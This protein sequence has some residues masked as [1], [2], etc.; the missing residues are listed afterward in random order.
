MA[1]FILHNVPFLAHCDTYRIHVRVLAFPLV[2]LKHSNS[3]SQLQ[4]CCSAASIYLHKCNISKPF[5]ALKQLQKMI[6]NR[7]FKKTHYKRS[8]VNKGMYIHLN[9][10]PDVQQKMHKVLSTYQKET[11][12]HTQFQKQKQKIQKKILLQ[13]GYKLLCIYIYNIYISLEVLVVETCNFKFFTYS[14]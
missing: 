8:T 3:K 7:F 12:V 9:L 6:K 10:I 2:L 13:N 4:A 14:Y 5:F 11:A 1:C